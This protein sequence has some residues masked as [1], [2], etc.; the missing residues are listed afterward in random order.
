M[1]RPCTVTAIDGPH[2]VGSNPHFRDHEKSRSHQ[3]SGQGSAEDSLTSG[4]KVDNIY[5]TGG[6]VFHIFTVVVN[7]SVCNNLI[8]LLLFTM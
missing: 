1:F 2:P 5:K 8:P 4:L 7:V 6:T 3:K